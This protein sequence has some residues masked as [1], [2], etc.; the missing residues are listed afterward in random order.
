[1]SYRETIRKNSHLIIIVAAVGA[2]ATYMLPLDNLFAAGGAHSLF[3][4]IN[5]PTT[6][7]TLST[8]PT[9][10][11]LPTHHVGNSDTNQGHH[12]GCTKG[13]GQGKYTN[14]CS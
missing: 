12:T 13:K 5:I 10:S 8:H 4:T 9:T 1:M 14:N 7:H 3:S 11:P 2:F 6:S